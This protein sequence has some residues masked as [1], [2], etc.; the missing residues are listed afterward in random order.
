MLLKMH[1]TTSKSKNSYGARRRRRG[2]RSNL[3]RKITRVAR[4]VVATELEEALEV[5][6]R[7]VE[8]VG[9][10]IT[11]AGTISSL[12]NTIST[13]TG[14]ANRVGDRVH[15]KSVFFRYEANCNSTATYD[16]IRTIVF[17]WNSEGIPTVADVL[18]LTSSAAIRH[19]SQLNYSNRHLY[20]ILYD[21]TYLISDFSNADLPAVQIDKFYI[22]N[23]GHAQWDPS[24]NPVKG[25]IYFLQISDSA[26]LFPTAQWTARVKFTDA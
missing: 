11:N 20:R 10:S 1:T 21:N 17:K 12:S 4:Q 15:L 16:N 6:S 14:S 26:S 19:L 24:A 18:S 13:G 7:S 3:D 5:K 22:K 9:V 2:K 25:H 23:L 8:N